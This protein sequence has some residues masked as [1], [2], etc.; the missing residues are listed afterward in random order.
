MK[1]EKPP[2]SV[3]HPELAKEAYGWDPSDLTKGSNKKL[4]WKCLEGHI[5]DASV[6]NRTKGRNCPICSNKKILPGFNDLAT[7]HPILALE[8]DGWDP[9]AVF[10]GSGTKLLWKCARG[11]KFLS[12]PNT[13]TS[14][15]TGCAVC[16]GKKLLIGFNDLK[17]L[18]P[19]LAKEAYGWNPEEV[20]SGS[21]EK[22]EWLCANDH[23]F[24]S[25]PSGRTGS[26]KTGCPICAGKRIEIGFND[27]K[28]TFP[29]IS[30]EADGW[31]PA[32][33]FPGT[34][35]KMNWMCE[36]GHK[37]QA[38]VGSRTNLNTGCP[39]C[40]NKVVLAGF[41]DLKTKY[42]NLALEA[43][44]WDPSRFT[45]GSHKKVNWN[46]PKGHK[47]S[48]TIA[49]RTATKGTGCP[50]CG[51]FGFDS[52]KKGYMYLI[53]N[54]HLSMLQ[55]GITND[56]DRRLKEHSKTYWDLLDLRGPM[57]G[58]LTQQWE[59]SIL[60][61]LKAKGADLSNPKI[62]GKFDGYSEAWSKSTFEAKSIKELMRLTEEFE[63][64]IT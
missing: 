11:H 46:C 27:L 49:H 1:Q 60:R 38:A 42:P 3:T 53:E 64:T 35:K 62:A 25:T 17:T 32:S 29:E 52:T 48:A 50:S 14:Q 10:G 43:D 33:V 31:D 4:A 57:D 44:G 51:K 18:H 19:D 30:R 22:R 55:I 12:S 37:Y 2:I 20:L 28:T 7:T 26:K 47:Y 5:Y 63:S 6:A 59:T 8:A 41:N 16:S 15:K 24:S 58:D 9:S 54:H 23:R 21:V 40:S 61:M 34:T 56:P 39:Y 36:F 45:F 13:R